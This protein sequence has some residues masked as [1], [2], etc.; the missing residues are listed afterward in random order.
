MGE[1]STAG[2][3]DTSDHVLLSAVEADHVSMQPAPG[4]APGAEQTPKQD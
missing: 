3:E 1:R 4:R 2:R